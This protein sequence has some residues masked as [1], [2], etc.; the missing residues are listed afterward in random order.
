MFEDIIDEE[1]IRKA[2][3]K[4]R[5]GKTKYSVEAIKFAQDETHNLNQIRQELIDEAYEFSGYIRFPVFE[6][7][8][9]IVDA[10]HYRDKIV[11][12]AINNILKK[13]YVPSFISDSYACIDGRG[14]HECVDRI[15]HFIRK[16]RWEYGEEAYIVKI[17]IKKFFYN[18]DREIL[19][20]I[21]KK[22]IKCQKTQR[23]LFKIIDSAAAIDPLGMPLGNTLSQ[24]SAN[25][26]LDRL[27]Q[28]CK[29]V[30]ATKYYVR[31][32]DDIVAILPDKA[33]AKEF[34][35]LVRTFASEK[36]HLKLN[37]NK[38]KIFPI[39]QGV[40]TVGFKIHATHRL[41]RADSKKRIK[42]KAK[43]M[44]K[45]IKEGK[46]TTHKAEQILNSWK[47]HAD[48]GSS[49]NFIQ[50]LVKN[51]NLH[52]TKKGTIKIRR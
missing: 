26:T 43:A 21:L 30:L 8:E 31:Y 6:P 7:K 4:S 50:K 42:R 48:H 5:K 1:N 13:K 46:L 24:I 52:I 27:D 16:A 20:N 18:I 2:Y 34:L 35:E 49:H 14:T 19:K 33:R 45:L 25:I 29:R 47:G 23:L 28:Y 44:P 51:H 10:P 15:Q 22:K 41:L 40:N 39:R 9:R 38:S 3:K 12:L 36:L 32:M 37:K 17:D 11:Q